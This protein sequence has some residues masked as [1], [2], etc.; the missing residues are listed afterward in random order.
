LINTALDVYQDDPESGYRLITDKLRDL[1]H[2][3]S[4]NRVGRLCS[5]QQVY[6]VFAKKRGL[7]GR[8]GPAVHDDRVKRK[9]TVETPNTLWLTDISERR[10]DDGKS[11]ISARSRTSG[12][13]GSSATRSTP[14]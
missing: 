1:G 13:T 5:Q 6:S 4:K 3:A 12:P 9:F 14:T 2:T 8:P 7:R 10:T 11:C